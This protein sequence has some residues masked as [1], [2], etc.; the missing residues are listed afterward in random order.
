[1]FSIS[2]GAKIPYSKADL[3]REDCLSLLPLQT[4]LL[5]AGK[6][7]RAGPEHEHHDYPSGVCLSPH[8]S[9]HS[10]IRLT[11]SLQRNE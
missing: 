10:H 11:D 4:E 7:R 5:E 3:K 1:M 6:C 9:S 2:T 8:R